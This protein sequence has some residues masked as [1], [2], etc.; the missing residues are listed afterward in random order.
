MRYSVDV[1]ENQRW[2]TR[3]HQR[4]RKRERPLWRYFSKATIL[5]SWIHPFH[6]IPYT[7]I[8]VCLHSDLTYYFVRIWL[9]FVCGK[10]NG[11]GFV[12]LGLFVCAWAIWCPVFGCNLSNI[13]ENNLFN[14]KSTPLFEGGFNEIISH[15]RSLYT[16]Y[17]IQ[18]RIHNIHMHRM[19]FYISTLL[20]HSA[21]IYT[22]YTINPWNGIDALGSSHLNKLRI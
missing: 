21:H 17:P 6:S 8:R 1:A 7:H 4:E 2:T 13:R 18:A 20:I 12:C 15:I 16:G 14:D 19:C 11:N 5:D 9:D 3:V 10:R 22:H